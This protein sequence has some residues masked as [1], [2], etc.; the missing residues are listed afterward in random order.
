MIDANSP[1]KQEPCIRKYMKKHSN[2][3]YKRLDKDPGLYECWN[4]AIK[5]ASSELLTNANL[6]DRS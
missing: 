6:D 4:A 2:I 3:I 5:M 1:G